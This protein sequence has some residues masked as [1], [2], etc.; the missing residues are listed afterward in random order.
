MCLVSA[1]RAGFAA[2]SFESIPVVT[3]PGASLWMCALAS[4]IIGTANKRAPNVASSLRRT[5]APLEHSAR[6]SA[7]TFLLSFAHAGAAVSCSIPNE[8]S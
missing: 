3:N 7:Q 5:E 6:R 8:G 4:A 2:K 1:E